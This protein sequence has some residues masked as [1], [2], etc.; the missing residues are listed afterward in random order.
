[1]GRTDSC[2]IVHGYD[3][4]APSTMADPYR[5]LAPIRELGGVAY[6]P[7][8]DRYVVLRYAD[9]ER[10]L[11]DR[12]SWSAA[13][14]S[15][16]LIPVC[17]RAQAVLDAGYHR[18]PTLNN[19]DPPRHGPMRRAVLRCMTPRRMADLEPQL[20][21]YA[22]DLVV[23]F[24]D[25]PVV[26]LI[27][28]LAFPFPGYAAFSLLGFPECDTDQLK[29]WSRTRVLLTYGRLAEDD[30]LAVAHEIVAFW[31]YVEAFVRERVER[32]TDDLTS[33]LAR[34]SAEHPD[35]LTE[36]DIV[37]IA[38]SMAL[39][40]HET[41]TN[42]IGNGLKALLPR[43]SEWQL[44]IDHPDL[45]PNAVEEIL[46]YDASVL[47]HRRLAKTDV[48]FAAATVPAGGKVF[49]GL[50]P[51]GRDP[52]AFA[53][54]DAFDVTRS[55]AGEHLAFGK[56]AH[57]CL[58]APLARLEL[59]IVLELLTE[60]LPGIELMPDQSFDYVP[61]ALF[62]GLQQLHVAPRG[63]PAVRG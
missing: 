59:R 13:N 11:L 30:Q 32:P 14:A 8:Y 63:L 16:P 47:L 40:G 54:P 41:T 24:A 17:A 5:A 42:A 15:S 19:A 43:R 45:I 31:R 7:E 39:A 21:T 27:D 22:R 28:A 53:D 6:L 48:E 57:L 55:D 18:V 52:E 49:M 35:Q 23:G 1:M 38:Y 62:R 9:V 56:G 2:P 29:A 37:N 50:G 34:Y 20:R 25:E 10:M 3:F 58:G 4:L 12:E 46:R 51:S 60:L 26:E 61:N 33:D 36:A 44:L